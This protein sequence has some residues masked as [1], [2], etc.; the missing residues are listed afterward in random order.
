MTVKAPEAIEVTP[1]RFDRLESYELTDHLERVRAQGFAIDDGEDEEGIRC[2][3]APIF[4]HTGR[5]AAAI[6]VSGPAF[7]L[8]DARLQELANFVMEAGEAISKKLGYAPGRSL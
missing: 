4:D 3:G 7:R 8:A 1:D 2:V 5:V 6:S